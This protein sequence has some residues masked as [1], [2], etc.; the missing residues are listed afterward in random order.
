MIDKSWDLFKEG[1]GK[2]CVVFGIGS[3][4]ANSEPT[5]SKDGCPVF[6]CEQEL[7][8]FYLFLVS[9]PY[10]MLNWLRIIFLQ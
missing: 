4:K 1:K 5:E 8:I 10:Q 9:E 6:N 7:W 2:F 3:T